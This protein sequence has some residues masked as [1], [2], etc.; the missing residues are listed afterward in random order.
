MIIRLLGALITL[1]MIAALSAAPAHG[2][3]A[4]AASLQITPGARADG[5]GRAFV[6]LPDDATA[7]WWNPAAMAYEKGRV[8]TLMHAQLVPGLADDV[9]YE[10]LGYAMHLPG[11]GGIGASLIY[12]GYGRSMATNE[13]GFELGEFTS[14]EISPQISIGTEIVPSIAA[15]LTLKWVYVSLAPDWA[16]PDGVAGTGD[17]FAADIAGLVRVQELLPMLPIP[18]NLGINIQNLG[19]AI[20]YIDVDQADPIGR[21]LKIGIGAAPLNT[22]TLRGIVSYDLNKSLIYRDETPIHNVGGEVT[23]GGFAAG[24]F[25]YIYDKQGDIRDPTFGV[26]FKLD[27]G[28]NNLTFDYA[29][30]PQARALDRVSK[31]SIAVRF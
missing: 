7:T 11:W 8:V 23:Y 6:A 27:L 14:Y 2:A 3:T 18:V 26:G 20:S 30:V 19:P 12:L 25:G 24:R 9:Y 22:P 10:H 15:G 13:G 29:S 28:A 4:A 21:N 17:T 16:T 5:M 31:F 1:I